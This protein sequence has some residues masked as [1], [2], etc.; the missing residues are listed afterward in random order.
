MLKAVPFSRTDHIIQATIGC[1]RHAPYGGSARVAEEAVL[2]SGLSL[3]TVPQESGLLG[4]VLN[5]K[6]RA[7]GPT[8]GRWVSSGDS[9]SFLIWRRIQQTRDT[10]SQESAVEGMMQGRLL[11]HDRSTAGASI[12]GMRPF[13][14]PDHVPPQ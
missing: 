12:P 10:G 5:E 2:R 3:M 7:M 8:V 1:C 11:W 6:F 9:E 13:L 14:N 4:V